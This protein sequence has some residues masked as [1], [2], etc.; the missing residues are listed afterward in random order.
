MQSHGHTVLAPDL[1]GHGQSENA[2]CPESTYS[3]PGYAAIISGLF[4]ALHWDCVDVVGWSLGGHIGLEL[5]AT[6][7]RVRSLLVVGTPPVSLGEVAL[8]AFLP[9][10]DMHL[11]GKAEFSE[12]EALNYGTAMMGGREFLTPELLTAIRRTD[13]SARK[14]MFSNALNGVGSDE[15]RTVAISSK[16]IC[17]VHGEGEPFV[18]LDY[19]ASLSYRA[20][21]RERIF[22]IPGAGHAPHW[23]Q[24]ELF[25]EILLDF[26]G[27]A[28]LRQIGGPRQITPLHS[29]P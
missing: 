27:L 17:V 16:P 9:G 11:A 12:A 1:P 14:Y 3:F 25:N 15:R 22:V 23:Q 21:W 8:A 18:R 29:L 13:G 7:P 2:V 6:E 10:E 28:P 26:L 4:D 5:L 20:L 24:P 19:L